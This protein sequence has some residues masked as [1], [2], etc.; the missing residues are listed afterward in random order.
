[1]PKI[2]VSTQLEAD[3][4][5]KLDAM[6]PDRPDG[7][8]AKSRAN[9]LAWVVNRWA[10]TVNAPAAKPREI[11][12]AASLRPPVA[13]I[14]PTREGTRLKAA[15]I[16]AGLTQPALGIAAG[17]DGVAVSRPQVE[18]AERAAS[19]DA[20]PALRAWLAEHEVTP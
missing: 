14:D 16:A 19:L 15:R 6:I 8:G 9:A 11:V 1:M 13:A 10:A 4:V 2:V 7:P 12:R 18:R 3:V 5:A 17:R 20:W